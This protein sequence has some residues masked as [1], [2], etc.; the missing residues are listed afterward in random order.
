L[1]A[2]MSAI[3]KAELS[4]MACINGIK[5]AHDVFFLCMSGSPRAALLK[6][7]WDKVMLQWLN[8]SHTL[9]EYEVYESLL[10]SPTYSRTDEVR[11]RF[12]TMHVAK[13]RSDV[14]KAK[15][16]EAMLVLNRFTLHHDSNCVA[17]FTQRWD[18]MAI[19]RAKKANDLASLREIYKASSPNYARKA[20]P[21]ILKKM[22]ELIG[23]DPE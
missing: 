17:W 14:E 1:E 18:A 16:L 19:A 15:T 9:E 23:P 21:F 2:K 4:A 12:Y 6:A 10:F 22:A 5:D 20:R 3:E 8:D 11:E 7:S 13:F